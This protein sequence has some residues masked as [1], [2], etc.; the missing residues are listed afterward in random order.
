MAF[1][2]QPVGRD[3][4][5]AFIRA[6]ETAFGQVLDEEDVAEHQAFFE[7]DF[8]IGVRDRGRIVATASALPLE[9]TLPAGAGEK[10]PTLTVPGVTA[11][12]VAPT[13]RRRGLLTGMMHR[14][15][16]DYRDRGYSIAILVA[17]EAG[18]Y[19]RFGYGPAQWA[20]SV[21]IDSRQAAFRAGTPTAG[22]MWLVDSDEAGKLLPGIHDRARRAQPGELARSAQ[23]WELHLK[24][25]EKH[26]HGGDGRFYAVHESAGGD[27]DGWV[28]YRYHHEGRDELSL[29]RVEVADLVGAAPGVVAALWRFVLDL[30]LVGEVRAG[31]RPMDEPLRWLLADGRQMR[32]TEVTD[33]VWVRIVDVAGALAARGYGAEGSLVLEIDG[34]RFV[35]E[36]GFGAGAC[37]KAKKGEK[38]DLVLGLADLGAIYLGGVRPSELAAAGRVSEV[39]PG[40]LARADQAFAAPVAPFCSIDF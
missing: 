5:E 38:A 36:T 11:V 7:P 23:W 28:S 30:D 33:H 35:L 8:A 18:I 19:G 25:R 6:V 10:N 14:Q 31:P 26:R 21:A 32:T 34:G 37:R 4:A 27:A 22:R 24:D 29:D 15:L 1:E 2:P 40:A 20:K 12:G 3:D 13:H 39:R 16:S 9:L 17:A